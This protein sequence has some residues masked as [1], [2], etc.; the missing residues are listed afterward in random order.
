MFEECIRQ[1]Q[2]RRL[3][4]GYVFRAPRY[5]TYRM[6]FDSSDVETN[7][8]HNGMVY[9]KLVISSEVTLNSGNGP[10][11]INKWSHISLVFAG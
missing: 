7:V 4:D 11:W 9:V 6:T 2:L 10:V 8:L 5:P 3:R 1:D